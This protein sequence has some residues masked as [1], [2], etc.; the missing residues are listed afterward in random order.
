LK[1]GERKEILKWLKTF[2]FLDCYVANI[3]QAVNV[4]TRK[5]DGLKSHDYHIFIE[6]LMLVM[7]CGYF[8]AD[9]W[10]MLAELIYFY[11]RLVLS[12]SQK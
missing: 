4:D 3:K 2:K 10:K 9:L 1:P 11:R 12:K 6:M 8:K 7:F 5:L